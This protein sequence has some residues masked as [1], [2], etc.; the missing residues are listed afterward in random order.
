ME[1]LQIGYYQG[2]SAARVPVSRGN[3]RAVY[4][5]RPDQLRAEYLEGAIVLTDPDK[6][7][8]RHRE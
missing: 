4:G 6:Q 7:A 1:I 5:H 8:W 2:R 3:I